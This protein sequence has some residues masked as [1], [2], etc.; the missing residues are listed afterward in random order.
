MI[1]GSTAVY[2]VLGHPVSHSRS[3]LLWN[4]LFAEHQLDAVY[5]ALPVAPDVGGA[6]LAEAIRSLGL[7]AVNLTI[8]HK[9]R[10]VPYLDELSPAARRAGAVNVVA[11][12]DGR[13]VGDNT[14]GGGFFL[15]LSL[16]HAWSVAGK[17]V[18]LLGAGGAA[19]AIAA[20]ALHSGASAVVLLN[21]T[22]ERAEQVIE[23]LRGAPD[24]ADGI[25]VAGPLDAPSYAD[26]AARADLVVNC[27]AGGA[28]ALIASFDPWALR[29]GAIWSDLNYW[30]A[31]PPL[32]QLHRDRRLP[33]QD[34][35]MMLVCQALL[36]FQAATG[37]SSDPR[38]VAEWMRG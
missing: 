4:R 13:L 8:P 27:T 15:G 2:A 16:E 7:Q 6:A 29:D 1:S 11:V 9:T 10:I 19:R 14:D 30:S 31:D 26:Q 36:A 18:T 32:L 34:G 23:D 17:R 21:R 25:L 37:K 28:D 33:V 12:R 35:R 38:V 24:L 3:P 5:V 22:V 20:E